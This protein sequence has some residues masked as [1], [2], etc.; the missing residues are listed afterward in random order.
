VKALLQMVASLLRLI[1][2]ARREG[3]AAVRSLGQV[4]GSAIGGATGSVTP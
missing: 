3:L 2:V 1:L 4:L